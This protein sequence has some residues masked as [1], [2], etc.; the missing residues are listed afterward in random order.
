VKGPEDDGGIW[1]E[2]EG[3]DGIDVT[4]MD[5]AVICCNGEGTP[6]ELGLDPVGECN[7]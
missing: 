7:I 2:M 6:G 3:G 1:I 5:M 4:D